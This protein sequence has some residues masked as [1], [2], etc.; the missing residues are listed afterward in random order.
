MES[1]TSIIE[2][3]GR[4]EVARRTEL[5][6][7]ATALR[8]GEY[9]AVS[10]PPQGGL[11]T[12]FE[13]CWAYLGSARGLLGKQMVLVRNPKWHRSPTAHVAAEIAYERRGPVKNPLGRLRRLMQIEVEQGPAAVFESVLG[14]NHPGVVVFIDEI[15]RL[16]V[17][18]QRRL[19]N[20]ARRLRELG[21]HS[22][23]LAKLLLVVGGVI[24][25]DRLDPER[26][27]PFSNAATKLSLPDLSLDEV[28]AFL[29]RLAGEESSR[30]QR[31]AEHIYLYTH[32][33]PY[34]VSVLVHAL[35]P[36]RDPRFGLKAVDEALLSITTEG[37]NHLRRI[38]E[39]LVALS[40]PGR[41]PL[42]ETLQGKIVRR[43]RMARDHHLEHLLARGILRVDREGR[44]TLR[45]AV[46]GRFLRNDPVLRRLAWP[47]HE[48]AP[49]NLVGECLGPSTADAFLRVVRLENQLR[50]FIVQQLYTHYGEDWIDKGLQ[51]VETS[52]ERMQGQSARALG[53]VLQIRKLKDHAEFQSPTG[54]EPL[55]TY[56]LLKELEQV[57][58]KN[59]TLFRDSIPPQDRFKVYLTQ[60]NRVRNRLAHGRRLFPE[61][62]DRL[63]E[64][65]LSFRQWLPEI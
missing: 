63:R 10:S 31:V 23:A 28:S 46:Y 37:D 54:E 64:I 58:L 38:R 16:D 51:P 11:T 52:A 41:K 17:A 43:S 39:W 21:A 6:T 60:L 65:E 27:S 15:D 30:T 26:V 49:A 9:L 24:E 34:F 57:V 4:I 12:F 45:N 29:A 2:R 33:H 50:N 18:I 1:L 48:V 3:N 44:V 32:G 59:W 55:M 35:G 42:K 7:V 14:P 47:G 40:E 25:W 62:L 53:S 13:Q 19:F 36:A 5:S 20:E 61:D 8:A 56:A 22:S